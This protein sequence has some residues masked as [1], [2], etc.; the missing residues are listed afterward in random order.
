[1]NGSEYSG[2]FPGTQIE[3]EISQFCNKGEVLIC[4]N[5]NARTDGLPDFI[6]NDDMND[7]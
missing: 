6:Q 5:F 7:N 4:G 1:V 3:N 2:R